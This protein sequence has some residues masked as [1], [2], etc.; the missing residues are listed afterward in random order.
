MYEDVLADRLGI[1]W[2]NA[3]RVKKVFLLKRQ[4]KTQPKNQPDVSLMP[5]TATCSRGIMPN[6]AY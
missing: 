3:H 5:T 2:V 4:G 1:E 6:G